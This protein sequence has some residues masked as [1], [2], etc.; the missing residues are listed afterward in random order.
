[1]SEAEC[2]R[3]E[4]LPYCIGNGTDLGFGGDKI[5][6]SQCISLDCGDFSEYNLLD[7]SGD[8]RDLPFK[9]EVLDYVFSSHL[10]EDFEN[11]REVVIEWCRVIK[12]RGHLILNLPIQQLYVANC[13]AVYDK[14]IPNI[15]HKV[16]M[17]PGY[18]FNCVD[19]LPLEVVKRIDLHNVY[20]FLVVFRKLRSF[21]YE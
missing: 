11:T 12:I 1:M 21:S 18:L 7:Y 6:D 16:D 20:S 13:R 5:K 2:I 9:D 14:F 4:V 17:S 19:G 8:A 15:S 3:H 10:L